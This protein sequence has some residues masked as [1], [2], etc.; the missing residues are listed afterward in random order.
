MLLTVLILLELRSIRVSLLWVNAL[1]SMALMWL[2]PA[3]R[4][5]YW[6]RLFANCACSPTSPSKKPSI[7]RACDPLHR[8][9]H[10][11][12]QQFYGIDAASCLLLAFASLLVV[13]NVALHFLLHELV[14]VRQVDRRKSEQFLPVL[15]QFPESC[16]LCL[17]KTIDAR[18]G[19]NHILHHRHL[20][21]RTQ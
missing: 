6:D 2:L 11:Y 17:Q 19:R 14:Q 20:A 16:Q 1:V 7:P 15:R 18:I 21:K 10:T 12:P 3:W 5:Q 4:E 9:T 13:L 8:Y